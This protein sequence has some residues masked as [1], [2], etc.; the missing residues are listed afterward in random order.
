MSNLYGTE[1]KIAYTPS[2]DEYSVNCDR[3]TLAITEEYKVR[4]QYRSYNGLSLLKH[5]LHNTV[6]EIKK[7][8]GVDENGHDIKVPDAEAIQ[9]ANSKID[10]I[11]N[12]FTEWLEAQSPEFKEQLVDMY[13]RKFNCFVRL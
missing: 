5:A 6:P 1:V 13:N 3:V 2:M 12:G 11:R 10:E 7:S 4:G 8:I 9:L